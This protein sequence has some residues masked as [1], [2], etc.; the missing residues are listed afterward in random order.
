MKT[1]TRRLLLLVPVVL[2]L[3]FAGAWLFLGAWLESAGGRRAVERALSERLGM[4]V[5]L[6]GEFDIMLL[7]SIGVSGTDLVLGPP[8]PDSELGRSREYAVALA[9][10]PLLDRRLLIQSIE[11]GGG[12][13]YPA[14]V[15]PGD[16]TTPN[17][18]AAL[19]LPEISALEVREFEIVS[20]DGG[21]RTTLLQ[22]F[23]LQDFA[24]AARL[25]F[26]L[27]VE[28]YGEFDGQLL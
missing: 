3:V 12:R 6:Q 9:V 22:A 20:A 19:Q 4:P 1:L 15:P 17:G 21:G 23:E 25:L 14:R 18:S 26:R 28:G 8:G 27:A 24:A 11:L 2:L 16:A 5:T 13:F 7:P 10:R